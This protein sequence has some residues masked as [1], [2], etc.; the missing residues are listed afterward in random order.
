MEFGQVHHIEYI[1]KEVGSTISL[2]LVG[3]KKMSVL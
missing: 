1:D 3:L 2:F